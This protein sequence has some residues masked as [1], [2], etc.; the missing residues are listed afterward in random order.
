ML[1]QPVLLQVHHLLP[2]LYSLAVSVLHC[3]WAAELQ[4]VAE[5]RAVQWGRLDE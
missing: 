4:C 5:I 1:N 2:P 3:H